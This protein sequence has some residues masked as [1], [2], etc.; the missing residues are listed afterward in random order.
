MLTLET[1]MHYYKSSTIPDDVMQHVSLRLPGDNPFQA[2][3][4]KKAVKDKRRFYYE[5]NWNTQSLISRTLGHVPVEKFNK[6]TDICKEY[7]TVDPTTQDEYHVIHVKLAVPVGWTYVPEVRCAIP[8]VPVTWLVD[9]VD[10]DILL[11]L[12][13]GGQGWEFV[14]DD[15]DTDEKYV[16]DPCIPL[17]K[18]NAFKTVPVLKNLNEVSITFKWDIE[19]VWKFHSFTPGGFRAIMKDDWTG[20]TFDGMHG[21]AEVLT[22]KEASLRHIT[23]FAS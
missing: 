11:Y 18:Q 14:T 21:Y 23:N 15:G 6:K 1:F 22:W 17:R 10:S 13:R 16:I 3:E 19:G 12:S 9:D 5:M 4:R 8:F 7:T 20:L 2:N